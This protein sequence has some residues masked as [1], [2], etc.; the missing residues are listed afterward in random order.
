M[1]K[2]RS[3]N[4][5]G[6]HLG[7]AIKD[8]GTLYEKEGRTAFVGAVAAKALGYKSFSGPSKVRLAAMKQYGLLDQKGKGELQLSERALTLILMN[9]SNAEWKKAVRAA[10]MAPPIF[11]DLYR[12]KL[13]ASNESITHTLVVDKHFTADGAANCIRVWRATMEFAHLDEHAEKVLQEMFNSDNMSGQNKDQLHAENDGERKELQ[14][15]DYVQ[16]TINGQEQFNRPAQ[17]KNFSV[18]T[19][20]EPFA[21]FDPAVTTT[22]VSVN[23]LTKCE[24]PEKPDQD[25]LSLQ[26]HYGEHV[27]TQGMKQYPIPLG[28]GA[29]AVLI[30]PQPM[31][32]TMYGKLKKVIEM[33]EDVLTSEEESR[34]SSPESAT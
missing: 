7:D 2:E 21:L 27:E 5:P 9:A 29:D 16:A 17:I 11:N 10:A 32:G 31:T 25:P 8:A 34:K 1:S 19:K 23:Q 6:R 14:I 22:G 28:G 13:S 4:Y 3:P 15:G 30:V 20:G 18:S 26:P 12:D 33:Y 24:P